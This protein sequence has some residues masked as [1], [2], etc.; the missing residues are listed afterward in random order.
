MSRERLLHHYRHHHRPPPSSSSS[1]SPFSSSS[2]SLS[3]I[4]I[5]YF[6]FAAASQL[7]GY[8]ATEVIFQMPL[9]SRLWTAE[10]TGGDNYMRNPYNQHEAGGK[11]FETTHNSI[12]N[13]ITNLVSYHLPLN[14]DPHPES[15]GRRTISLHQKL[16]IH[17]IAAL[18][19]LKLDLNFRARSPNIL[20]IESS[21]LPQD[22]SYI[23]SC[24][25]S[26]P[27]AVSLAKMPLSPVQ[28]GNATPSLHHLLHQQSLPPIDDGLLCMHCR[29]S[30][31]A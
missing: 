6:S 22:Q 12:H 5:A 2:S 11:Y 20:I 3:L 13:R 29:R 8:L 15:N 16:T 24:R 21:I 10:Q 4:G 17:H 1:S 30:P 19:S 28:P 23:L 18:V 27:R 14:D 7:P 25:L 31:V 9:V 26:P